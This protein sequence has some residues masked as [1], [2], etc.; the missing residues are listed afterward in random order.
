MCSNN[1]K[2]RK[3]EEEAV[4]EKLKAEHFLKWM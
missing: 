2:E 3:D 1:L 4:F